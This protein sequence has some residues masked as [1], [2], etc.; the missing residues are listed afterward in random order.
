MVIFHASFAQIELDLLEA[1]VGDALAVEEV[2]D[3][4]PRRLH[5]FLHVHRGLP[6]A[7]AHGQSSSGAGPPARRA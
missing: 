1:D 4:R 3:M 7:F 5:S 2:A 6:R